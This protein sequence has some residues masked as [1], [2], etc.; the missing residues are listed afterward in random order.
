[1]EANGTLLS[2]IMH[3]M[4]HVLGVGTIWANKGLVTGAGTSNPL[5]T[6]AQAT[7][8]Y[9]QIFGVNVAGVPVENTGGGGTRDAH[10][11]ES[12]LGSELMTGYAENGA[13]PLSRITIGSLADIGYV[14]NMN[15]ADAFS[16]SGA[17][18]RVQFS[19]GDSAASLR[20][21]D[22]SSLVGVISQSLSSA[23]DSKEL[24]S[25]N[26]DR[27]HHNNFSG[28]YR[29]S[30]VTRVINEVFAYSDF[31]RSKS[32]V[33]D[34]SGFETDRRDARDFDRDIMFEDD[35]CIGLN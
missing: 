15:A 25:F 2:V 31:K 19:L 34:V 7:A 27:S 13:M 18:V 35:F 24:A 26:S 20:I 32:L 1:M 11:R 5:F 33:S 4:G 22:R 17:A 9:N 28:S 21:E 14:V 10:W 6:G 29:S 3:E 16:S 12:I 8:A 23:R 30:D